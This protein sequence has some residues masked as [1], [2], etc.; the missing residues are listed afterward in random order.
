[1]TARSAAT[2]PASTLALALA[3]ALLSA[4]AAASEAHFRAQPLAASEAVRL[5]VRDTV[6]R[7]GASGCV[8]PRGSSRPEHVCAALVRE[9]GALASF[10]AAGRPFDAAA[11]EDCNRRAR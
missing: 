2:S 11:L 4:P 9:V 7:C 8:A 5:V 1:M 3:L 10:S 6:F